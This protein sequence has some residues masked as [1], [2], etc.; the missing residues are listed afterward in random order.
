LGEQWADDPSRADHV[1]GK[2]RTYPPLE[3][4]KIAAH[5]TGALRSA[6]RR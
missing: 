5:R 2:H 3:L 6:T 4:G 1:G